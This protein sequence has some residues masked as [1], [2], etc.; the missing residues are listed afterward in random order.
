MDR[1]QK[2]KIHVKEKRR[3]TSEDPSDPDGPSGN[4]SIGVGADASGDSGDD[5]K[6]PR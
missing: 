5:A 6:R 3:K 1:D 4:E 2:G